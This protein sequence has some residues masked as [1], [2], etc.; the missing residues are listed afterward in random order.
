MPKL[1]NQAYEGT[2]ASYPA[3]LG[4]CERGSSRT[5]GKRAR[6]GSGVEN[7]M[8]SIE[9]LNEATIA[10]LQERM[11]ER[12]IGVVGIIGP[13]LRP[14]G[15]LDNE[16]REGKRSWTLPSS[17]LDPLHGRNIVSPFPV[18]A[19]LQQYYLGTWEH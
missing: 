15:L 1:W 13:L 9:E 12:L 11:R 7:A 2:K 17:F 14:I 8:R 18:L 19:H 3:L 4:M 6:N 5:K 10:G 16:V